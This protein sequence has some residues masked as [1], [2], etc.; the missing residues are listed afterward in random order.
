MIKANYGF[1]AHRGMHSI[2]QN[3]PENSIGAF[4]LAIQNRFAIHFEVQLTFDNEALVFG[5]ENFKRLCSLD[6]KPRDCYVDEAS[7]LMLNGTDYR[8]LTLKQALKEINGEVPILIEIIDDDEE[9][10]ILEEKV[11]QA[12]NDYH[13]VFAIES[14]NPMVTLWFKNHY[15]SI[16]RGQIVN[17]TETNAISGFLTR[18]LLKTQAVNFISNPNFI[19]YNIDDLKE[20]YAMECR[21]KNLPI[22]GFTARTE[23]QLKKARQ[24]CD[25]IIFEEIS[26]DT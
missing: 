12:L 3:L 26:V 14:K 24:L 10:G 4:R 1:V 11:I 17:E 6:M 22:L 20:S 25:G 21:K 19:S 5:D 16:E 13:G 2:K 18:T 7:R 9:I 8:V 23:E 15:P